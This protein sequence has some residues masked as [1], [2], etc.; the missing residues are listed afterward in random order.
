M[1][2]ARPKIKTSPEQNATIPTFSRSHSHETSAA[3]DRPAATPPSPVPTP[4][5]THGEI[6]ERAYDIYVR[7]GRHENHSQQNWE[8][9]E[10]DLRKYGLP[11]CHAQ[12]V[13]ADV[14]AP[15]AI[16]ST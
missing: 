6:A 7:N 8:Q 4:A 2:H 5:F 14:F 1:L 9:A 3:P 16:K 12:H 15:D 10:N 13:I 11:S